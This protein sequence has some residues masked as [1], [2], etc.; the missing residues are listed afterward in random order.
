MPALARSPLAT[1][2]LA[3]CA[4]LLPACY[5]AS[6]DPDAS[7]AFACQV[8]ADCPS[9]QLC[10]AGTCVSDEGPR[11]SISGPEP[12]STFAID[13]TS[14][15]SFQITVQGTNLAL[16]SGTSH[17]PGLGTLEVRI[18]GA[19]VAARVVEGDLATGFTVGP[20]DLSDEDAGPHRIQVAAHRLDGTP[21]PNP[22]ALAHSIFFIDDGTPQIAIVEPAPGSAHLRSSPMS[23]TLGVIN[24]TWKVK[25][26]DD[27]DGIGHTHVYSNPAYPGCLDRDSESD[28]NFL[29]LVSI[30]G[31]GNPSDP[32]TISGKVEAEKLEAL[33]P[34]P[35][36][37]Q[38][39]LQSN[40]HLPYPSDADVEFDA[41]EILLVGE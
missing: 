6:F 22:S 34:G 31:D 3:A 4:T 27:V 16:A 24:Y 40:N 11:V 10:V 19:I 2:L 28:C 20:F 26:G 21:Y 33:P 5:S 23:V 8:E 32:R 25:G 37:L 35:A 7:G 30:S 18:D 15:E 38:A 17:E 12:L 13:D 29:Y 9:E 41:I 1:A 14:L 39:G 36:P